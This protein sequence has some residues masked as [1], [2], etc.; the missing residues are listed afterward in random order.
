MY[1]TYTQIVHKRRFFQA[2]TFSIYMTGLTTQTSVEPASFLERL[3][4]IYEKQPLDGTLR[5]PNRSSL[6]FY[7]QHFRQSHLYLIKTDL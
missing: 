5:A 1:V 2:F 6:G 3:T 4:H 7:R